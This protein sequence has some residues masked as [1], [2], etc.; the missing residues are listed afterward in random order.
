MTLEGVQAAHDAA[1]LRA[2]LLVGVG[3]VAWGLDLGA[4]SGALEGARHDLNLSSQ[5]TAL[6]VALFGPVPPSNQISTG[7]SL[8]LPPLPPKSSRSCAAATARY[9]DWV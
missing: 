9:S 6:A 4:V 1:V 8:L 2:A 3:G 5:Q 7:G